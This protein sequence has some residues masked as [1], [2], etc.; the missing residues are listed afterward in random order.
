MFLIDALIKI[1]IG[2]IALEV[3]IDPN[4]PL[5]CR[6]ITASIVIAAVLLPAVQA[7]LHRQKMREDNRILESTMAAANKY[8]MPTRPGYDWDEGDKTY[9]KRG[10]SV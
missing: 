1:A 5:W 4:P 10:R 2:G 8:R 7:E 3:I 6:F 9:I